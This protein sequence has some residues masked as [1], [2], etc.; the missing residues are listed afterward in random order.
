M[1]RDGIPASPGIVIGPAVP[2]HWEPPRAPHVTVPA[3]EIEREVERFNEA[4]EYAK[5]RILDI[6]NDTA[7]RLGPIEA[8]IFEPQIMMLDDM[9]M[10]NGTIAYI[11]DN[12]L[13]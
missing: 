3:K 12:H 6:K 11:R 7:E 8:Q 4:R 13:S 2:L 1:I 9:D 10:V 5:Q